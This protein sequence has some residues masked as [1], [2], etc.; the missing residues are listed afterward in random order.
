MMKDVSFFALL[1]FPFFL[2]LVCRMIWDSTDL[3]ESRMGPGLV[4]EPVAGGDVVVV[5]QGL[6]VVIL[7]KTIPVGALL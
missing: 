4:G 6:N 2:P 1:G 5:P 7:R 3:C